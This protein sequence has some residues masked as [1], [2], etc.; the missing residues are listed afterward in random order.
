MKRGESLP[1]YPAILE[2]LRELPRREDMGDEEWSNR[3]RYHA[4]QI[5]DVAA[6][7][8]NVNSADVAREQD[9]RPVPRG[10]AQAMISLQAYY[11]DHR[12]RL[13]QLADEGYVDFDLIDAMDQ[14]VMPELDKLVTSIFEYIPPGETGR[15]ADNLK[16]RVAL[17]V[18]WAFD[19]LTGRQPAVTTDPINGKPK[20]PFYELMKAVWVLLG[21][22]RDPVHRAKEAASA[23]KAA[24]AAKADE[25]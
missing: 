5:A 13:A 12:P 25:P 17:R 8:G 10:L 4:G 16:P 22:E 2:A 9:P 23:V 21:I 3:T 15:P 7:H 11:R 18:A 19:E 6:I 14:R 24:K 1:Q 20:G